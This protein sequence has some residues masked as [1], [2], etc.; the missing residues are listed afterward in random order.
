M[1]TLDSEFS[2][3]AKLAVA[4]RAERLA[5]AQNLAQHYVLAA[6][7]LAL[8]PVPLADLL[9]VMALQVKL[10]HGLAGHYGVPFK[11]S[12]A[13]SLLASLLSG[14]SATLVG[15]ALASLAKAVP[16][17]GSLAG[18]GTAVSFASVTYAVGAIFIRH[19]ESGGTLLDF[20]AH[21]TKP[22]FRHALLTGPLPAEAESPVE[23]PAAAPPEGQGRDEPAAK[24]G[25]WLQTIRG[26]GPV[27]AERLNAAGITRYAQLAALSPEQVRDAIGRNP[28]SGENLGA[29][30]EQAAALAQADHP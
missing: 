29:W 20:D 6:A 7:S 17:L 19:F 28:V 16:G 24:G 15:R 4:R 13:Q 11:A 27:Y 22:L 5:G 23:A 2:P 10:V 26:I 25:D 12:L 18:G 21:K 14:A 30:I 8:V 3:E 9:G 1:A